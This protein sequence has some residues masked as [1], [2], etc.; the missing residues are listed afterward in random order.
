MTMPTILSTTIA[1]GTS[2]SAAISLGPNTLVGIGMPAGWD[3]AAMSFQVTLDG[4]TFL[5]LFDETGAEYAPTVTLGQYITLDPSVFAGVVQIKVRS[6]T[7]GTP[8]NQLA[9]RVISLVT[10]P[11]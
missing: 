6:G 2:L 1:S 5:D 10:R 4:T 11:V 7:T 3:A 9:D 8:V